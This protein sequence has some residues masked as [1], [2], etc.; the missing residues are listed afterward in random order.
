MGELRQN[1]VTVISV[2]I[3]LGV[4]FLAL[5]GTSAFYL[6]RSYDNPYITV[7]PIILAAILLLAASFA[8]SSRGGREAGVYSAALR[9]TVAV[10]P[11]IAALSTIAI[12]VVPTSIEEGYGVVIVGSSVALFVWTVVALFY[13]SS[14]AASSA[15]LRNYSALSERLGQLESRFGH[16]HTEGSWQE[17]RARTALT[18]VLAR[19]LARRLRANA[20][21]S[22]KDSRAKACPG[23]KAPDTLS[24]GTVYT[25][26]KKP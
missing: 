9:A 11:A 21:R 5:G 15:S 2:T 14:V 25:V 1:R 12:Y 24:S 20:R 18:S 23:S 26:L 22:R 6:H 4:S 3:L 17:E 19:S 10:I 7:L 8:L 13:R 16:L